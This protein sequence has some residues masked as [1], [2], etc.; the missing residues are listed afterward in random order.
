[1]HSLL[2]ATLVAVVQAP[3]P[4]VPVHFGIVYHLPDSSADPIPGWYLNKTFRDED[5]APGLPLHRLLHG[6]SSDGHRLDVVIDSENTEREFAQSQ[7]HVHLV[8][9]VVTDT[10]ASILFWD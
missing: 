3:G 10:S 2:F 7:Y 9:A 4:G 1:M 5:R 8:P 6:T